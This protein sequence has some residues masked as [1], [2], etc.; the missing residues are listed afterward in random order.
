MSLR[1]ALPGLLALLLASPATAEPLRV[2]SLVPFVSEAVPEWPGRALLVAAVR[3]QLDEPTPAAVVDLGSPHQP[4]L[5]PLVAARP[6]LIV[7]DERLHALLRPRLEA[8]GAEVLMVR[9]ESVA[10]TFEGLRAVARRAGAESLLESRIAAVEK[11][12]A[13]LS[14]DGHQSVLPLFG[15]PGSFLLITPRTWLGDLLARLGVPSERTSGGKETMPGY[16]QLADEVLAASYPDHVLLLAH[17]SPAVVAK[18]FGETWARFGHGE[19][20]VHVLDPH[21]FATNPGLRMAEAA[22][23][24]VALLAEPSR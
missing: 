4:N 14:T 22:E 7:A 21:L 11:R 19:V 15:A 17:G 2:A 13:A 16:V 5:E 20:P 9:A 23:V 3:R 8:M 18:A 6:D 1:R 12:L 10:A 24:V